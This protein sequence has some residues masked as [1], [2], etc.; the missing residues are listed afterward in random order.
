[1]NRL[2][3]RKSW[4]VLVAV[5]LLFA[6]CKGETPTA[7][8]PGGG[9][10]PGGTPP[11]S[12][13]NI[14]LAVSNANPLIDST[15]TV[16]ATVTNNGQPVPNGTAVEFTS[17][18]GSLD[19]GGQGIIKTTTNGVATVTLTSGSTGPVRVFATVNNVTR[20]TD[21]TFQARPITPPPPNTAPTIASVTPAIGR[22]QGGEV[23][24]ITGTNFREPVRVLFN[25]G[26]P[27][28]IEASVQSVT[29]TQIEVITPP[30]NIGVDQQ[31]IADVIVLTQAGSASE[32]RVEAS[33]A[34]TYRNERLTPDIGTVSPNSGP[35]TGGTRVTIFGT[36]FQEPVQ[37][38][39]NTAEARVL[40]VQFD[41]IHVE[42]P[43]ARDT[44]PDGSGTV[45]GPVT[46]LVRNVNSQ[47][48][49]SMADGFHYK[50]A[51]QITAVGPTEGPFTGGTRVDIEGTGFVSP[52]AVVIGG[53]AAQ[54]VF[55][56]GTKITAITSPLAITACADAPGPVQVTNIVNG[57]SATGPT[58]TYRVLRPVI[59]SVSPTATPGGTITITVLNAIGVSRL[60][61]GDTNLLITGTTPNPD[62]TTTFTA[63][64]PITI[65][66]DT[67]DCPAVQGAEREVPTPVDVTYESVTTTCTDVLEN[68][69]TLVPPAA[70]PE[71]FLVPAAFS[72]FAATITPAQAG[73]PPVPASVAPSAPQTVTLT[74]TGTAPLTVNS[75]TPVGAGCATFDISTPTTPATV[76]PCDPFPINVVYSG[77]TTPG[78][79][80]CTLTISTDAGTRTL[81]LSGRS[82]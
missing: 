47:T 63:T 13:V 12:G 44:N 67:E 20:Q 6:A 29:S 75:V 80:Q 48:E 11:P 40:N 59:L 70:T 2:R 56:S 34:F 64:V 4:I 65:D 78:T 55:V 31:L 30:V 74:N 66:L 3:G 82:Q 35:V 14:A 54:P 33:D 76:N 53:V 32:Q 23:V 42:T 61:L 81:T 57:D 21:V 8:P 15:V 41:R 27:T 77:T 71:L 69:A 36:G 19:G 26:G 79:H 72:P 17:S 9:P 58:F 52:V 22:P 7:P 28:A 16:T 37:V 49:D 50:A 46:V 51:M 38:L 45:T 1:M 39:F 43:A 68:G 73:P 24:R 25:T 62:G 5:L 18:G 60:R 10:P